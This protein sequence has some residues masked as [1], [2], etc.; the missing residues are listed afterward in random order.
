MFKRIQGLE[1]YI[2]YFE[3]GLYEN[4]NRKFYA[5]LAKEEEWDNKMLLL[6]TGVCGLEDEYIKIE[7]AIF[8]NDIIEIRLETGEWHSGRIN[9]YQVCIKTVPI[10]KI[11]KHADVVKKVSKK[12]IR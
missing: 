11:T 10:S 1:N 7:S 3:Y 2:I 8:Q 12:V 6:Q 5:W 4:V 9:R